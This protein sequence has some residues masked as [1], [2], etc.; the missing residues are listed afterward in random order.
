MIRE[1]NFGSTKILLATAKHNN[2]YTIDQCLLCRRR[3]RRCRR[4]P[5]R[6]HQQRRHLR[7]RCRCHHRCRRRPVVVV[8]VS[9][10]ITVAVAVTLVAAPFRLHRF[11]RHFRRRRHRR[12][13]SQL[14]RVSYVYI[15]VPPGKRR[16]FPT[17]VVCD[18]TTIAFNV[19][20]T[21]AN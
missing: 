10:A 15:I 11:H 12:C 19:V 8:A 7:C 3:R 2:H 20:P 16:Q 17:T 9:I 18:D 1:R 14:G 21:I 13:R 4:H 6:P 5:H